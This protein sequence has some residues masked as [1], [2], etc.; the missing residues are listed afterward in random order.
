MDV[1]PKAIES[2]ALP[3]A[4]VPIEIVSVLLV[5]IA[6]PILTALTAPPSVRIVRPID[7]LF[8]LLLESTL[9]PNEML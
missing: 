2:A 3:E 6:V 4:V 5:V 7:T 8:E 9:T 1:L